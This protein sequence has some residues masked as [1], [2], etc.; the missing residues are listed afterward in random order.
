MIKLYPYISFSAFGRIRLRKLLLESAKTY[1]YTVEDIIANGVDRALVGQILMTEEY[2]WSE[3]L[4][5][6]LLPYLLKAVWDGDKLIICPGKNYQDCIHDLIEDIEFPKR[7]IAGDHMYLTQ[8]Q[9]FHLRLILVA[10]QERLK[11]KNTQMARYLEISKALYRDITRTSS[12][13]IPEIRKKSLEAIAKKCP[14]I[15]CFDCTTSHPVF[16]PGGLVGYTLEQFEVILGLEI[17][18][19]NR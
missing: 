2:E 4:F 16:T 7:R 19:V 15:E 14:H 10:L 12:D 13:I 1:P 11:L 6:P 9:L 3:K 5:E 18:P 17:H 8:H